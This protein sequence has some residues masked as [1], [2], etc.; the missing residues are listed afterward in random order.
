MAPTRT[1]R[2]GTFALAGLSLTAALILAAGPALT[3]APVPDVPPSGKFP[4]WQPP[5]FNDYHETARPTQPLPAVITAPPVKYTISVTT[6]PQKAGEVDADRVVLM[7][8]VPED[9]RVWIEGD[10]TTSTG[11]ERFFKSPRMTPDQEYHYMVRVA[12]A[13]DGHWV[14]KESSIPVTAGQMQ[15]FFIRKAATPADQVAEAQANLAKLSPEDRKLAEAQKFCVVENKTLLGAM[16]VPVKVMLKD[17]P[18]FLC[19]KACEKQAK[20]DPD[21]TLAKVKELKAKNAKQT[22]K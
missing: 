22:G 11:T 1:F 16:G 19:C 4:P 3:A 13:E 15:C 12:W 10:P 14:S 20:A 7:A 2:I 6:V 5:S 18:V 8:H 21:K 17:Q 9:A